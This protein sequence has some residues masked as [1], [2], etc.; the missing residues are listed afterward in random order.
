MIISGLGVRQEGTASRACSAGRWK[1]R[2]LS[3]V[4]PFHD[5]PDLGDHR[6]AAGRDLPALHEGLF[7]AHTVE[8]T[9]SGRFLRAG[10]SGLRYRSN[11]KAPN[12]KGRGRCPRRLNGSA[13]QSE[14]RQTGEGSF[15]AL[16]WGIEGEG[17]STGFTAYRGT[18]SGRPFSATEGWP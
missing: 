10:R 6:A 16:R 5:D 7:R 15:S 13:E 9:G 18:G 4:Q 8:P 14:D 2:A 1:S 11:R 12:K 3:H 17:V